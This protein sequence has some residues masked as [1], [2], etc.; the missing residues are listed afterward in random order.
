MVQGVWCCTCG[1]WDKKESLIYKPVSLW[2]Q[3]AWHAVGYIC[4][5]I[6][7]IFITEGSEDLPFPQ[8]SLEQD[9]CGDAGSD[10]SSST[11]TCWE[12]GICV[13]WA[14][15]GKLDWKKTLKNYRKSKFQRHG[16]LYQY[17]S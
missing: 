17:C 12:G 8:H 7:T 2:A 9:P 11:T 3:H 1:Y 16:F 5:Y 14:E 15:I 13:P 4:A 6:Y 10:A